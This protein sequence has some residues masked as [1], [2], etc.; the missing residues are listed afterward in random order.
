MASKST[1]FGWWI[2]IRKNWHKLL[3][4]FILFSLL[5]QE[6]FGLQIQLMGPSGP[7]EGPSREMPIVEPIRSGLSQKGQIAENTDKNLLDLGAWSLIEKKT[8]TKSAS[9]ARVIPLEEEKV[10]TFIKRF[11]RVAQNEQKRFGIPASIIL[12]SGLL[13]SRAGQSEAVHAANNYFLLPCT[14]D[15]Q[16]AS[17]QWEGRCLRKYTT[18]WMSFRDHTLFLSSGRFA[19]LQGKPSA[20]DYR[21]WARALE[22]RNYPGAPNLSQHLIRLIEKFELQNWDQG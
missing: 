13:H 7:Q 17:M 14:T 8:R 20:K 10:A 22:Q 18:A 6:R 3:L 15:W 5:Q 1:N 12:A 11:G 9:H 21:A 16:G 4:L 19:D 2:W